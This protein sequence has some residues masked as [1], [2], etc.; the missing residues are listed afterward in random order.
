MHA[1]I[2]IQWIHKRLSENS[3]PNCNHLAERFSISH[4][5]AQ[6]DIDYLRDQ[7]GAPICYDSSRKGFYYSGPYTLPFLFA[8]SSRTDVRHYLQL[9]LPRKRD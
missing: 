4:R 3:Y 6:R 7:L 5:Q 8:S 1:N 9:H 2:R